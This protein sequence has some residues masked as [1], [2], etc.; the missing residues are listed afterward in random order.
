[1][2]ISDILHRF[3]STIP[4][5]DEAERRALAGELPVREFRKGSILLRQGD[6]PA[7]CFF[8]LQGCVR[9]F[10]LTEEG[11]ESSIEFFTEEEAVL[12][13]PSQ[14]E[15]RAAGFS[16]ACVEDSVILVGDLKG[17]PAMFA[18]YPKLVS[19]TRRM[20]ERDFARTQGDFAAFKALS[21][22]ARYRSLLERRPELLERVPQYQLASYIGV[23]PESLS[24]IRKRIS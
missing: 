21:P 22:E 7:S 1:M 24:R 18:R 20:M 23:T 2:S 11:V 15:A 10:S 3:L 13:F 4:D 5:L 9:Q 14:A 6:V 8:I 17:I 12:I 19:V 16:L